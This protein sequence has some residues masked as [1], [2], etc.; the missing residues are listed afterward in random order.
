MLSPLE[1]SIKQQDAT[2]FQIFSQGPSNSM[3]KLAVDLFLLINPVPFS[4][5]VTALQPCTIPSDFHFPPES[6][7]AG[8]LLGYSERPETTWF[9]TK[10]KKKKTEIRIRKGRDPL[11]IE[12]ANLSA[13]WMIVWRQIQKMDLRV[14]RIFL[15][16]AGIRNLSWKGEAT[17]RWTRDIQHTREW[18]RLC[19]GY[20]LS[21]GK[22]IYLFL[23][24]QL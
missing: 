17:R 9:H 12:L 3:P 19:S 13:F 1:H 16:R 6:V 20:T 24:I 4:I 21:Y 22:L 7:R 23:F 8:Y 18:F 15:Q 2:A 5:I 11:K 10:R 14:F